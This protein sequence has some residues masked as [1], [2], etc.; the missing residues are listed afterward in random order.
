ML[1]QYIVQMLKVDNFDFKDHKN[2]CQWKSY[3]IL[4]LFEFLH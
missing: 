1:I 3:P 4:R 2:Y